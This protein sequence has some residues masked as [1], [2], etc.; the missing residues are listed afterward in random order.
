MIDAHALGQG[1]TFY[2][3][4]NLFYFLIIKDDFQDAGITRFFAYPF[5]S[6]GWIRYF[7]NSIGITGMIV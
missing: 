6:N 7:G 2:T 3:S 5:L 1:R 4:R